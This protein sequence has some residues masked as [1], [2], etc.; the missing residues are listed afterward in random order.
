MDI[1]RIVQEVIREEVQVNS[2]PLPPFLYKAADLFNKAHIYYRMY[3]HA[4]IYEN[5]AKNP[6]NGRP[7]I[8]GAALQLLGD[9]TSIGSYAVTVALVTKCVEDILQEYRQLSEDYQEFQ[10]AISRSYPLYQP[11]DWKRGK[12]ISQ[13]PVPPSFYLYWQIKVNGRIKQLIKV[14]QCT[15]KVFWQ[16][17]KLSMCLCDAYLIFNNDPQTRYE[18][19]TELMANLNHYWKQLKENQKRL[20]EEIENGCKLADH[21]LIRLNLKKDSTFIIHQLK[22]KIEEFAEKTFKNIYDVTGET[23]DTFYTKGKIVPLHI[24]FSKNNA[25]LPL[26]PLGQFPPWGGQTTLTL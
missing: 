4:K 5:A 23:L 8:Y 11:L 22:G 13:I 9:Y 16:T 19:C 25:K 1:F 12:K 14:I 20:L 15:F 17:F 10:Q 26:I 7:E 6:L 2:Y 21:I 18:A 24:N 3:K